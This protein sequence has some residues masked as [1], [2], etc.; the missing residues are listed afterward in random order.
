MVLEGFIHIEARRGRT[1][2]AS[3]NDLNNT[4]L[5]LNYVIILPNAGAILICR[6]LVFMHCCADVATSARK[7]L[8]EN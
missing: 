5:D 7:M 3:K 6:A 2:S 4:V 1:S 8:G